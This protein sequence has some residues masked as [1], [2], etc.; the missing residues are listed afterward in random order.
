MHLQVVLPPYC[1]SFTRR[2]YSMSPL[3]PDYTVYTCFSYELHITF[4]NHQM[5]VGTRSPLG[6]KQTS[7]GFDRES[8][9]PT[10]SCMIYRLNPISSMQRMRI[11]RLS[12]QLS[13][14]IHQPSSGKTL[15]PSSSLWLCHK[16]T[17]FQQMTR[18]GLSSRD[19]ACKS[20]AFPYLSSF[21][22]KPGAG[23]Q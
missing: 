5:Q 22:Y 11:A 8:V 7:G 18:G 3:Y 2:T 17:T 15:A 14:D 23:V 20:E 16:I 19:L 21:Q 1:R 13:L 12:T 6:L 9:Q 4:L 10:R